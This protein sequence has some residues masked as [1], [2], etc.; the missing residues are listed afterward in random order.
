MTTAT[1]PLDMASSSTAEVRMNRPFTSCMDRLR[2]YLSY[3]P[4][5]STRPT[6][7]QMEI[8]PTMVATEAAVWS[9]LACHTT[10]LA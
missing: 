5:K 3:I 10:P 4:P 6:A 9:A 2:P 8:R 1:L 7:L